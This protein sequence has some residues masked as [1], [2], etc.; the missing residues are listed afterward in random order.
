[1]AATGTCKAATPGKQHLRLWLQLLRT[2]RH[3]EAQ[4]RERLRDS[5][6]TTLPR[7]D[8]LAALYRAEEGLTMTA[9]SRALKVSNGNVTGIVERLVNDG[10]IVRVRDERDRRAMQVALTAK[11]RERFAA[12]A[13]AHEGWIG[14]IL[15]PLDGRDTTVL[16]D[17]LAR[18]DPRNTGREQ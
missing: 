9:L 4:V 8:V 17:H 2:T 10:F 7:F 18:V 5:F 13:K 1:M 16:S 6:D 14:E 12:M 11:G 3:V 15:G